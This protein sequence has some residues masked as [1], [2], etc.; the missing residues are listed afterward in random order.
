M[1]TTPGSSVVLQ[2]LRPIPVT[3]V[4]ELAECSPAVVNGLCTKG[5]LLATKLRVAIDPDKRPKSLEKHT[6]GLPPE[7][8]TLEQKNVLEQIRS[9]IQRGIDEPGKG[10]AQ[11]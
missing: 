5:L 9:A 6:E 10:F 2:S 8:L 4:C 11:Q 7:A 3:E 1:T